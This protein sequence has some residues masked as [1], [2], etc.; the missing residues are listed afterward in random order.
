MHPFAEAVLDP[1][2]ALTTNAR[3]VGVVLSRHLDSDG[4]AWRSLV[5][6][7]D[8]AGMTVRT[9]Q[10]ALAELK[11]SNVLCFKRGGDGRPNHYRASAP[12]ENVA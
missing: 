6:L 9:A 10:R 1:E 12:A 5:A 2:L 7:A 3:W 8:E 11:A 4:Q